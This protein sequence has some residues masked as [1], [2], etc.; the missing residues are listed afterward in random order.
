MTA[1]AAKLAIPARQTTP[2]EHTLIVGATA[3]VTAALL[4]VCQAVL[5][6]ANVGGVPNLSWRELL[7]AAIIAGSS[8]LVAF[9][10][11]LVPAPVPPAQ[12]NNLGQP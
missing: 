9:L 8:A 12:P 3:V 2:W 11:T 1:L 5:S 4:G 6:A 10:H 7:G